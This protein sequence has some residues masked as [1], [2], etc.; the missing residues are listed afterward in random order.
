M[1]KRP[2]S[3]L[4]IG[5]VYIAGG[6]IGLASH[7]SDFKPQHPFQYNIVWISLINLLAIVCGAYMLRGSNWARWLAIAWMAF[8]VVLSSFHSWFEFAIHSLLC[9]A[10][11]YFLFRSRATRYFLAT[12]TQAM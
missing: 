9:A 6:A 10:V 5:G 3:V 4:V 7:F 2:L 8:H 11:A 12:K 1:N